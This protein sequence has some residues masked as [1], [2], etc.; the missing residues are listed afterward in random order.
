MRTILVVVGLSVAVAACGER[1]Q[2]GP[3]MRKSDTP[4]WDAAQNPFVVPGWK[5]GDEASW[6]SQIRHRTAGQNDYVRMM[7]QP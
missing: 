1:V 7:P 4:A 3:S 2:S 6:E 5:S